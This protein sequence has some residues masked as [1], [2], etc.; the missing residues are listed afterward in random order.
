MIT[1]DPWPSPWLV[2][3]VMDTTLGA[4]AA[5]VAVQ[6]GAVASAWTTGPLSV[7]RP[8]VVELAEEEGCESASR[9]AA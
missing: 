5:A 6:L 1:P 4:T 2:V 8:S 3:T 9:V 7:P